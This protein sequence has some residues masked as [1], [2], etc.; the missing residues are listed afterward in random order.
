MGKNTP[1]RTCGKEE[2]M[3]EE[4][5]RKIG[6]MFMLL[7]PNKDPEGEFAAFC[8]DYRIGNYALSSKNCLSMS[9][10]C[11]Q[12]SALRKATYE[13]T[14]EYPFIN[15][16]QEGGWVTRLYE[17][18]AL[19]SGAMSYA[20]SGADRE[21]MTDVGRRLG[22]ILRATGCNM[23]NAPVLDV[24]LDP[25]NPIIGTRAYGDEPEKVAELGVGFARGLEAE[26][27]LAAV[28]HFPGHGNV[29]SDTHLGAA[30]NAR[31]KETLKK[32]EFLPFA[33]AFDAG[34]GATMASHVIFD[35]YDTEPTILSYELMTKLLR[36][37]MGFDGVAV[38]DA[39][40][41][42]AVR[43]ERY[44]KGEAA[45]WAILAGCDILLY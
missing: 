19:I 25:N 36:D 1:A 31:D 35:A 42:K 33:R 26:G 10:M 13:T 40:E 14:G 12:V 32:T 16:D 39:M 38:T 2:L 22:R 8:R 18:G 11:E 37:E 41:M 5:K 9:E 28:K 17:G 23:N 3:T 44:P 4:M 7:A 45:V 21:K 20:A 30:H 29:S 43:N 27:V 24:N 34:I 6:Q 15:I